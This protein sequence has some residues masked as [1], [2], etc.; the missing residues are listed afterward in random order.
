MQAVKNGL[1]CT[2]RTPFKTLLFALILTVTTALLAVSCCVFGA[3]RGYLTDCDAYFH[4]IVELEYLGGDYPD[5]GVYD[6]ALAE[7]LEANRPALEALIGSEGVLGFEPGSSEVALSPDMHRWDTLVRE[8]N[9][10]VLRVKLYGYQEHLGAYNVIVTETLYSRVD[11][12]DKLILLRTLDGTDTLEKGGS[13]LIAG[14]FYAGRLQNP[15]FQQELVTFKDGGQLVQLAP[16][17]PSGS[18]DEEPFRRYAQVLHLKNDT[19]RVTYT[20]AI[21]DLYPFH[22]QILEL[23]KGRFFTQEEYETKARVCVVS[24]RITGLLGLDVGDTVPLEILRAEGDIFDVSALRQADSGDYEIIGVQSHDDAYPYRIFLPDADASDAPLHPVN[25]YTLGQFRLENRAV[26]AF[27]EAAEPLQ[28]EGFRFFVYDQ[29]YAAATEPVE[30]LLFISVIFLA[31]CLLLALCAMALQ[32]HLFISRQRETARTMYAMGSG[33]A[34]VCVYFLSAALALSAVA[35]ACGCLIGK[36]LEDRVFTLLRDFATQFAD[37]DLRFSSSRLAVVRTLDFAPV[38]SPRAYLA[39]AGIL[40][41]GVTGFSLA[42]AAGSLRDRKAKKRRGTRLQAPKRLPRAS[43]LSGYFKYALLSIRRGVTRTAAVLLL[44]I[45]IGAFFGRLT[46]SLA[47][48]EAQLAAYREKAAIGGSATDN[49]GRGVSGLVLR[50]QPIAKLASGD[51][52]EN[53]CV[54]L[55]LGHIQLLGVEGGEQIPFDWPEYGSYVYESAFYHLSKGPAWVGTSSISNSPLFRY[56]ESGSV[57][58]LEGWSEA[59]FI[60]LEEAKQTVTNYQFGYERSVEY[61][62]GP[63]VC[64]LPKSTME[65][66]GIELGDEINAV[67]AYYHPK[68]DMLLV[69]LRLL[70]VASYV[71]PVGSATVFSP[72]TLVRPETEDSNYCPSVREGGAETD[73]LGGSTWTGAEL[74]RFQALGLSPALTYSSFTFSLRDNFRLDELR[75]QMAGAGFTWLHSGDRT[76]NFAMVEDEIYLNTTHSMERQIQYVSALYDALYLL[77]GVIGFT[78]AWLLVQSRRREIAV[79]RALGTQPLRIVLNFWVEQ[80]LLMT[81]GLAGGLG[82]CR[83]TGLSLNRTQA[84]LTAAFLVL[85]TLSTL[86]C[87]LAGLRKRSYAALTEPE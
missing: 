19:C 21:E 31:V 10:A 35:A 20:A 27:L 78:L 37:Q 23:T 39:A 70:V 40:L 48:Y 55:N 74:A 64:A 63:A 36:L 47:G 86:L 79:M 85:W 13:Y 62:T 7:A 25:G 68:W 54:T 46:A 87:L 49:K 8:P 43:R 69:P 18:G 57:E 2:L 50:S 38:S 12:T 67:A 81:L 41:A 14:R 73:R 76:R 66:R 44:G 52:V 6:E 65:E 53:C 84:L 72:L 1:R 17:L 28:A 77:T 32:S 61:R 22:Q 59:D 11:Y 16:E 4:T 60:R 56:S 58:W 82:L 42:F 9:A 3:V 51:L 80:L 30:E 5:E 24:E 75:D 71:A 15:S 83:L 45:I 33:R 34:H 26:P 29:G